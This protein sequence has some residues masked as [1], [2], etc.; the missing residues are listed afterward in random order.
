MKMLSQKLIY[1]AFLACMGTLPATAGVSSTSVENINAIIPDGDLNGISSQLISGLSGTISDVNVTLTIS[2]G[3]N[4]DYYAY[5]S[6]DGV[7]AV[8]LNRVGLTSS[9]SVGYPD[10]GFG[11][12]NAAVRFTFDDQAAHDVHLYR[13]FSF[14]LNGNGQLTGSWQPDGRA[15]NPLSA[16]SVFD[17]APRSNMLGAFN[18]MDPSGSWTLFVSDVSAGGEGTLINWGLTIT[19]VP[20]PHAGVLLLFGSSLILAR[21]RIKRRSR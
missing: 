9:S 16:G 7:S 12:D 11:P 2:G 1:L 20:E 15:I 18:G 6:H 13:N 19:T 3:F 5:I 4:G 21:T 14:A 10:A 8:L 17:S